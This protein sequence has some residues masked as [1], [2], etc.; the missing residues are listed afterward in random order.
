MFGGK[1]AR[2]PV[3]LDVLTFFKAAG[4]AAQVEGAI[5][6]EGKAPSFVDAFEPLLLSQTP[7]VLQ[8][9]NVP[10]LANDYVAD[11]NYYLYKQDIER[12]A[13]M[14]LEYYSFSIS[15][16]RIL[17]FA[18]P[19][20]PVNSQALSHYD[21]LINYIISKGMKP[22]VTL[23]H[24]DAPLQLYG[25]N[26]VESASKRLF[27]GSLNGGYDAPGFIDAFVNY[28]KIVMAHYADR[29]PIWIT[30]NEP[31][32]TAASGIAV[33]NVLQSHA[34]LYHFYHNQLNGT[35]Q[36]SM[37]MTNGPAIPLEPTNTSHLAAA[38]HYND[39][40]LGAFLDPLVFGRDYPSAFKSTE[41]DYISLTSADLATLNGT[42]DFLAIDIYSAMAVSP[43]VPT[44]ADLPACAA[45]NASTNPFY[46]SCVLQTSV[47]T[48]GWNL[49]VHPDYVMYNTAPYLRTQLSY[50]WN[51]W[52]LPVLIAEFGQPAS[53][54]LSQAQPDVAFDSERSEYYLSYLDE[55]LKSIWVD[56]VNVMGALAW[57]WVDNF[58]FFTFG[59]QFGLQGVNRTSMERFYKRSFFDVVDFVEGRRMK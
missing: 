16:P 44:P 38:Q 1:V 36:V 10:S 59:H 11:E 24:L 21:D 35:G 9:L 28:G 58:E 23:L 50:L 40:Y 29:V 32:S 33:N 37:K 30:V 14:G 54:F 8:L 20:S 19:G 12:L 57:S 52:R 46:P 4:S 43:A 47:A 49:G 3:P 55:V 2:I 22:I 48:T 31:Q 56:G 42:L 7:G 26:F 39:L 41:Q 34:Q 45:N 51:T 13:A 18:Y 27:Y 25:P 5:A 15:W 6:D 53:G 17:P